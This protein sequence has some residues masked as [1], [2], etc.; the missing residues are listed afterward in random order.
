MKEIRLKFLTHLAEN[1][2][3]GS[4]GNDCV[5]AETD[6]PDFIWCDPTTLKDAINYDCVRV[7]IT[8]ENIR[9][10]FNLVD[11]AIG[12]DK[13]QF[14]DRYL[15]YPL[16]AYVSPPVL[17]DT[18]H[19]HEGNN[20]VSALE[21]SFCGWVVSNGNWAEKTRD[22]IFYKLSEYKTVASGGRYLNNMPDGKTVPDVVE[23]YAKHKF[24]LALENSRMPGYTT[25]KIINAFAAQTVPIYWGDPLVAEVFNPKAFINAN[26]YESLDALLEEVKRID[27]DDD[28][29]LA[30]LRQPAVLPDSPIYRYMQEPYLGDYLRHIFCDQT[31]E[32]ARR[33]L[34]AYSGWGFWPEKDMREYWKIKKHKGIYR[35][36]HFGLKL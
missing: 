29:Y 9:P 23:F 3:R 36:L 1:L 13:L 14:G 7:W 28:A 6:H 2:V 30:M 35:L 15:Q 21:R 4:V 18:L 27:R 31:P 24:A 22:Q 32:Q 12:F 11:Y 5:V 8:G 10:D 25:E 20:P 17:R 19:K 34:N 33:R 26:E 16:Y